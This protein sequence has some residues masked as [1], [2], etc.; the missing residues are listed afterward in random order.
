MVLMHEGVRP[1]K[2][3]FFAASLINQIRFK[4][5]LRGYVSCYI[6][7]CGSGSVFLSDPDLFFF[8]FEFKI[9]IFLLIKIMTV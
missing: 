2:K 4:R 7:G 5:R 1:L 6:K 3:K 9:H 8:G